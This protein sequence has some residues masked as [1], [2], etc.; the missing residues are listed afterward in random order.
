MIPAGPLKIPKLLDGRKG[1]FNL[2]YSLGRVRNGNT[3][4]QTMPTLLER[5]G[6]FSQS[7]GAQ[8]PVT[9]FDPLTGNLWDQENGDD[10]YD[11][12]NRI[13]AGSNNGW[14]ETMGPIG[15]VADFKSIESTYAAGNL[16]QLPQ[17]VVVYTQN[18]AVMGRL[19]S[20]PELRGVA[21]M[22]D[23]LAS[24]VLPGR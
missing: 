19:K 4:T 3:L 21:A 6:D 10:A 17:F 23:E 16:Q 18:A 11:E 13:T 24:F 5:T 12:M 1:T 7:I 9:I 8:G 20:V 22:V 15:R 2:T 14:V